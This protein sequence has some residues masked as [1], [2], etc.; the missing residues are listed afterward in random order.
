[1]QIHGKE[2]LNFPYGDRIIGRQ[3]SDFDIDEKSHE[4]LIQVENVT[5]EEDFEFL[6]SNQI[7]H[8]ECLFCM[9]LERSL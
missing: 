9:R 6:F 2:I 5:M 1:M 3:H 8:K 7:V 4:F